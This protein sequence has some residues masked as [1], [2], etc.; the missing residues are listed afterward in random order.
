[1]VWLDDFIRPRASRS[2]LDDSQLSDD[3]ESLEGDNFNNHTPHDHDDDEE[4]TYQRIDES[5]NMSPGV[6]GPTPGV[7]GTQFSGATNEVAQSSNPKTKMTQ[8]TEVSQIDTEKLSFLKTINQRMVAREKKKSEDAEDRYS[9]TIADK[10]RDLPQRERLMA[11]HEIENTLFKYQMQALDKKNNNKKN[12]KSPL[13]CLIRR[14]N[15]S[16]SKTFSSNNNNNQCHHRILQLLLTLFNQTRTQTM[17][18]RSVFLIIIFI[19]KNAFNRNKN[20]LHKGKY[21]NFYNL[22]FMQFCYKSF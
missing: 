13:E 16:F 17:T 2:S 15:S 5:L 20:I 12:S 14:H 7:T 8:A 22:F 11:K 3:G 1:M 9:A 6:A 21:I 10:L 4:E 18:N 19:T